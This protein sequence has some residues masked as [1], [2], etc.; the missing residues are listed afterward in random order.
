[1][2]AILYT[3]MNGARSTLDEQTVITNNLANVST[4]GF[5]GQLAA[6]RAVPVNGPG[7][8][9]TRVATATGTGLFDTT[10]G[11]VQT[12]ERELDVAMQGNAWLAVQT[13]A[14]EAYTRR[15]DLQVDAQGVLKVQGMTVL[16]QGGPVMVPL[17]TQLSIGND[18]TISGIGLGADPDELVPLERLKL[19]TVGEAQLLERGE[20]GWFRGINNAVLPQDETAQ[21]RSGALEGS[22]VSAVD[23]MVAMIDNQRRY[24]MQMNFINKA[25][26]TAKQANSL[27][28]VRG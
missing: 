22:N 17:G 20:D 23:A 4:S 25:D 6:A 18:G 9:E 13:P 7:V 16:G 8:H 19:V 11:P 24:E 1:M 3:G 2:D 5:R 10:A 12:T 26:E 28:S 14:G 21:L 27:L 15:G